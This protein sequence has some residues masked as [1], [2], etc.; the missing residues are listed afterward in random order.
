MVIQEA[1]DLF[2]QHQKST[3]KKS[4]LKSYGKFMDHFQPKLALIDN[5]LP[6]LSTGANSRTRAYPPLGTREDT[7]RRYVNV[8][9]T[10]AKLIK[11]S[12]SLDLMSIL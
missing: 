5:I 6:C 2:K 10:L 7:R 11:K 12:A 4:T 1:I 9:L 3:V 8:D